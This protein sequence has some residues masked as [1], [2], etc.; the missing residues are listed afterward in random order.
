MPWHLSTDNGE[1]TFKQSIN[2]SLL[3]LR[4]TDNDH[5]IMSV[6][7]SLL[8]QELMSYRYSSCCS[9]W[10]K[11]SVPCPSMERR[12]GAHLP[13]RGR[14]PVG[15]QTT[16][17]CAAWPVRRQNYGYLPG[18]RASPPF[19]RY[20]SVLLGDRGTW[21]LTTCP[22]LL[23]DSAPAGSRTRDLSITSPTR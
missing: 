18:R 21:V 7:V 4:T 11:K 20:Q 13:F 10:G 23:P 2:Q 6:V 19:D 14:E 5:F 3:I 1:Q 8:D 22:E 16:K 12:W 15:G 9:C 17:V